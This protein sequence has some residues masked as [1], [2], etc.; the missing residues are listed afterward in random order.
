MSVILVSHAVEDSSIGT[1]ITIS[2]A[3]YPPLQVPV[4]RCLQSE[5]QPHFL[6]LWGLKIEKTMTL[7][8]H[9]CNG[10]KKDCSTVSAT[11]ACHDGMSPAESFFVDPVTSVT[12]VTNTLVL[13]RSAFH[14]KKSALLDLVLLEHHATC[15][16]HVENVAAACAVMGASVSA[17]L[18]PAV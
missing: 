14:S 7:L 18:R 3:R 1:S 12:S 5:I 9:C 17:T 11:G 16:H 15:Q 6:P 2:N 4:S 10:R 8:T 13:P